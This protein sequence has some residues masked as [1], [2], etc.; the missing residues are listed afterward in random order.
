M[1]PKRE[2]LGNSMK[3]HAV[4][5]FIEEST[6]DTVIR[7]NEKDD[8]GK[9]ASWVESE[10]A[11]CKSKITIW[12]CYPL[13]KDKPVEEALFDFIVRHKAVFGLNAPQDELIP[14]SK[15]TLPSGETSLNYLQYYKGLRVLCKYIY[16][17]ISKDREILQASVCLSATP[18][19]DITPSITEDEAINIV[20]NYMGIPSSVTNFAPEKELMIYENNLVYCIWFSESSP[21]LVEI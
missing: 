16:T 9:N 6:C 15:Q 4:E 14:I 5:S 13:N 3:R 19:V 2:I 10:T 12:G 1:K 11:G 21:F 18:D 17:S 20:R 7:L 8:S